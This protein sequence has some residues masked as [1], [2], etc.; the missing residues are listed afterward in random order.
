MIYDV[1]FSLDAAAELLKITEVVG[2]AMLVLRAADQIRRHLEN[3]PEDKGEFL[4]EGLYYIDEQPIRAFFLIDL[5]A[6]VVEI[7]DFRIL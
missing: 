1:E 4:S 7:T 6:M 5:D 3:D 2:S